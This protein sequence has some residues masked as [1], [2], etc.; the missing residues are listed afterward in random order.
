MSKLQVFLENALREKSKQN[1]SHLGDRSQYVGASDIA[2]CSRKAVLNK[3]NPEDHDPMTLLRFARG[4]A[5]EDLIDGIFR[6]GGLTPQ[7]EVEVRHPDFPEILCHIDFLFRSN[8]SGRLHVMELK[9]VN[10]I[11]DAP[12]ESW[13]NQLHV[14]MGL[15]ELHNPGLPIGGSILAVDLNAGVWKEFN[16]FT[17]NKILFNAMVIKG[18]HILSCLDAPEAAQIEPG[19]LC[20]YCNHRETCPA[21]AGETPLPQEVQNLAA[22]YL[23]KSRTRGE[24]DKA[25]KNLKNEI[26]AFTGTSFKGQS[27]T[28]Q[29]CASEVGPSETVDARRLKEAYPEIYDEVKKER[30]GYTRLDIFRIRKQAAA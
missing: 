11:P 23:E 3:L 6:A 10:G 29:V 27:D 2:G 21:F 8:A 30:A 17:P 25:I 24:L 7:R 19:I 20:G 18:R 22:R 13:V 14:Q 1:S 15:L 4:H 26:L 12:Y 9:T 28:L 5:A 16:S